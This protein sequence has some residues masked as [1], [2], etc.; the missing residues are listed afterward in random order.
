M[1]PTESVLLYPPMD[2]FV[3]G[4]AWLLMVVV[5]LVLLLACTN[6]ASFLL[7]RAVDRRKEISIRLA[8]G[9]TR[10]TLVRQL[11]TETVVLGLAGGVA[12]LALG[13]VFSASR[14]LSI[15]HSQS[16]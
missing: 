5:G 4:A 2:R 14:L 7:A 1:V 10:A 9:A 8:L 16:R 12:G 6:L 11:L 15:S 3:R 13:L